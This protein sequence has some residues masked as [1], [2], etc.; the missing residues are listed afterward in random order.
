MWLERCDHQS[1]ATCS[2]GNE[3][4]T[5]TDKKNDGQGTPVTPQQHTGNHG[6]R[7]PPTMG[8]KKKKGKKKKGKK[9]PKVDPY[10]MLPTVAV[11]K[12][13]NLTLL[14]ERQTIKGCTCYADAKALI[15]EVKAYKSTD[16]YVPKDCPV[17]RAL[18]FYE[19]RPSPRAFA[20]SSV[21]RLRKRL[22]VDIDTLGPPVTTK[23]DEEMCRDMISQYTT[24]L[25]RHDLLQHGELA[26]IFLRRATLFSGL[27]EHESALADAE[28]SI[29]LRH[30][31]AA[32]YY[33]AGH[34]C[35]K[36]G[37]YGKATKHF[38]NGVRQSPGSQQMNE[39]FRMALC[40]LNTR[41]SG[42]MIGDFLA[43]KIKRKATE[44]L[45]AIYSR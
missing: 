6:K 21:N 22:P 30:E 12:L 42:G 29:G 15:A 24:L 13:F 8:K 10:K 35:M 38:Q 20:E 43:E 28:Q 7:H 11:P 40:E 37:A 19:H 34:A 39:A 44:G 5:A 2:V 33:R 31:Q 26:D 18:E 16:H 25:M 4:T 36:L 9:G 41:E 27:G 45:R 23:I 3:T 32:A 14:P 1:P 17:H